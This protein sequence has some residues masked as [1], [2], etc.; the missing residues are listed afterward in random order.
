MYI[1]WLLG[2]LKNDFLKVFIFVSLARSYKNL[3]ILFCA[4]K[5]FK[6]FIC[7]IC[8]V[9]EQDTLLPESTG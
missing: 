4:K 1:Y 2:M 9:L 6:D 8:S 7:F 3:Y 5:L